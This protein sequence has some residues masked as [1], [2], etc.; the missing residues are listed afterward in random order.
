MLEKVILVI[1]D[2]LGDRPIKDLGNLTPLEAAKTPNMDKLAS[3]SECGMMYSLGRGC[4]PG[5]DTSHLNILGYDYREYYSGRGTIEVTG[6][7]M[8][9]QEGDVALRGNFGTVDE[10]FIIKDRRAGRIRG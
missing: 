6:V 5:S 7:G 10:N 4:V 9:L 2:G 3:E 8:K 1:C